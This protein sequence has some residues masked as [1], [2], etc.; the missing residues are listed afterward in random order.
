LL[1]AG[2]AKGKSW[3]TGKSMTSSAPVAQAFVDALLRLDFEGLEATLEPKVQ[4]RALVPGELVDVATASEAVQCFGRWFGDKTD[5]EL[6]QHKSEMLMDRLLLEYR[7]RLHKKGQPY[8]VEQRMCCFIEN[9]KF[10]VIDMVCSGFRPEGVVETAPS[11]HRF[12][13]GDLGCGSGLPREFR[14]RIGQIPVGH[15]LEVVTR[16]PSAK[17]D[18]PSM[19]RLLGHKV[20]SIDRGAEGNL[21]IR[22]E[23]AK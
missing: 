16:D 8:L 9:E 19:A 7:L 23:R 11:V 18:L 14:A 3:L 4:F 2:K 15:I 21:I 12:D 1:L 10:A 5:L 17:E 13:A 6:L 20:Q 22:V